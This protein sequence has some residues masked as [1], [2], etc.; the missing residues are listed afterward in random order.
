MK[1]ACKTVHIESWTTDQLWYPFSEEKKIGYKYVPTRELT[2]CSLVPWPDAL[3]LKL[4]GVGRLWLAIDVHI[5][6]I[7]N[8]Q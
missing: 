4:R 6:E 5:E 3:V 8:W 1:D 2:L 7:I